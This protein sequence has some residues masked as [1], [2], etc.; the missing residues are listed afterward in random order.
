M[1]AT[2]ERIGT[3]LWGNL[4]LKSRETKGGNPEVLGQSGK[5]HP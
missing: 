1:P 3:V 5:S 4:W 2:P